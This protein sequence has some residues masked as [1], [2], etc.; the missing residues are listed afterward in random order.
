[1]HGDGSASTAVG[2][3]AASRIST[4]V[5]ARGPPSGRRGRPGPVAPPARKAREARPWAR[6]VR[7]AA[8]ETAG[9]AAGFGAPTTP[10]QPRD[11]GPGAAAGTVPG[12]TVTGHG[13]RLL[14]KCVIAAPKGVHDRGVR[15]V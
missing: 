13:K 12:L 3:P 11:D 15:A 5:T 1:M 2:G 14:G 6:P 7:R 8:E 10:G 9:V 4:R